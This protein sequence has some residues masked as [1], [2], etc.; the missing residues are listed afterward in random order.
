MIWLLALL[1]VLSAQADPGTPAPEA[2]AAPEAPA[3]ITGYVDL[4]IHLAAHLAVPVYGRGPDRPPPAR[5]TP[6][7]ALQPQIFVDQLSGPRILVSL[8]YANPF[9]AEASTPEAMRRHIQRQLDYVEALCAAHPDRFGLARTPAEARAVVASGR[10]AVVHGIEGA[11]GILGGD[12]DARAWASQGVAVITP[13]HLAD[14]EIGGSWCQDGRLAVL[15]LPGCREERRAPERHGLT[16]TGGDRIR[17]LVDAGIIVDLAH[18]ADAT[19]AQIMDILEARG[20]A[21]VYTHA[22]SAT[23]RDDSIAMSAD[24]IRRLYASGGLAGMTANADHLRP[25]PLPSDPPLPAAHCPGSVDDFRLHWDGFNAIT[26]GEPVAWGSD[27]QGGVDHP[28]PAF[29]PDG[30][31]DAPEGREITE[32]DVKGLAHTGM[33][34]PMFARMAADGSDRRPLDASAERFLVIWERAL[35][36]LR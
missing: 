6:S 34:E 21:P 25:I 2:A 31:A 24:Q 11:T 36:A 23:V 30:C 14:N 29:G 33:V 9:T 16:A 17:A 18:A 4:H 35:A 15:N 12:A 19:F 5:Q 26:A 32:F 7:H 20:V 27:F 3:P 8:A 22:I 10:I 28:R 1:A 13:V